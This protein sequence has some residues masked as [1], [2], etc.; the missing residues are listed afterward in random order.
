MSEQYLDIAEFLALLE[1]RQQELKELLAQE[2]TAID[3]ELDQSR[4]GR[5]SR[6][7]MLQSEAMSRETKRRSAAELKRIREA[8][9]RLLEGEYGYCLDCGE[10]IA[11]GRL[12]I[13]PAA[14]V[15]VS[16]A[17]KREQGW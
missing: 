7:D 11:E 15:C 17:G 2:G 1:A 14:T 16:C 3:V 13:D 5:L 6:M 12:K 10:R 9:N 4:V 8:L